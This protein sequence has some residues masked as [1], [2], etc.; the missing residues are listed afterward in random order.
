[1]LAAGPL[2]GRLVTMDDAWLATLETKD[3]LFPLEWPAYA[4]LL[5]LMYA[6]AILYIYKRRSSAGVL[7]PA[8]R[9]LVWGC[10]SLLAVFVLALP[11]NA[12]RLA[13]VIQL[14]DTP[15]LLDA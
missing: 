13:I 11:L 9:G 15:R 3:Y 8:E 5:N 10:L 2:A 14:A 1:M 7:L 12:A 6:P 4:W